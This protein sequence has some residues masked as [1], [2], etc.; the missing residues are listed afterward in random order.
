MVNALSEFHAA[1]Q[2]SE[3]YAA[4]FKKFS[5]SLF[6]GAVQN[7]P[8]GLAAQHITV[9]RGRASTRMYANALLQTER[10]KQAARHLR[11]AGHRFAHAGDA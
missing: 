8:S 2:D 11:S 6:Q 4:D 3:T 5:E 9:R 10:N 7:A 1:N